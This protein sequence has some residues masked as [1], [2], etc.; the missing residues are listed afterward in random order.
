M[1]LDDYTR[2]DWFTMLKLKK[3]KSQKMQRSVSDFKFLSDHIEE[4]S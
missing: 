4:S 3:V 1:N 2:T